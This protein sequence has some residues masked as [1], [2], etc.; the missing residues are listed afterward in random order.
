MP[1]KVVEV[2]KA[3][4]HS[5]QETTALIGTVKAKDEA[6]LT[7][8]ASG[9][10]DFLVHAGDGVKKGDI[11]A[12]VQNP[13]LE[14][15]V[16]LAEDA[17]NIAQKQHDRGKQLEKTNTI[18]AE[19]LE[20]KHREVLK[21]EQMLAQAKRDLQN[22]Q[23][24]A[25]FNGVVGVF[26]IQEGGH[27]NVG[28]LLVAVYQ[29]EELVINFDIPEPFVKDLNSQG[30]VIIQGVKHKI[31]G[32]QK[33]ID[34]ETH[35]APAYVKF[36]CNNCIIGSNMPL[37]LVVKSVDHAITLPFEAVSFGGEKTSVYRVKDGKA[38]PVPVDLGIRHKDRIEIKSGV[39]EGD[40]IVIKG[41]AR[42][43]PEV[44]VAVASP[45]SAQKE[46]IDSDKKS[47][48]ES[49]SKG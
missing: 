33:L 28:D 36:E 48:N 35:M 19:G 30:E 31:S 25:P 12:V 23:F 11:I 45:E 17:L 24:I 22:A 34:S 42:L 43:Y 3:S 6:I 44:E 27:V 5:I 2:E 1:P 10:V 29:P 4:Y 13:M 32:F 21:A 7:A 47:A 18:A 46:P 37:E 38:Y 26:R 49:S 16:A 14:K 41:I 40:L 9:N 15:N 20:N 39:N 8:R